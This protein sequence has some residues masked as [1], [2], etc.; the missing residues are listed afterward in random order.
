MEAC[1][2]DRHRRLGGSAVAW[3]T[4]L[5]LTC[6]LVTVIPAAAQL[7]EPLPID[8][9]PVPA[10]LPNYNGVAIGEIGSL[11]AN[12]FLVRADD[13][14]AAFYN[15]AGLTLPVQSSVSGSAGVLQ[16]TNVSPDS[17]QE[18]GGS[19]QQV[20]SLVAFVVNDLFGH[21]DWAGGFTL[22]RVNAW[23]QSSD[24]QLEL[25]GDRIMSSGVA[26]MSGWIAN[27]A[28][29]HSASERLRVGASIDAQMTSVER[30]ETLAHR[31]LS[32]T[33][34]SALLLDAH[35]SA[36]TMHL[37]GSFGTQFDITPAFRV[38]A[39]VRTP[40]VPV[41]ESG[42]FV[43]ESV[44][45]V[46]S[47]T[48]TVSLFSPDGDAEYH[49]PFEFKVG[50]A[51]IRPRARIEVDLLT[52][53]GGGTYDGFQSVEPWTVVTDSGTGG[54]PGVQTVAFTAPVIDSRAVVNVAVGGQVL[55]TSN[56]AWRL[57]G[58]YATDQSPVGDKD[59]YF[60]R[61][62]MQVVTAGVSANT[63]LFLGSVGIR[64]QRGTSDVVSI[65]SLPTRQPLTTRMKVS[66]LGVVYSISLRF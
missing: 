17:F 61:V 1:V 22:A 62:P 35:G 21:A 23:S 24:G 15:P 9:R 37:R 38:G 41:Y 2:T 45:R 66:S 42:S 34:L 48:R 5:V 49:L 6:S 65:P 52:W 54:P 55:L 14:S 25:S 27:L 36:T 3:E 40:G 44:S 16:F 46:G 10:V 50:A 26:E 31:S 57:H 60:M 51:Y 47:A 53:A 29:G 56:G 64:Y 33:G 18:R 59:T 28:V 12:A 32:G 11:E 58:G 4:A 39:L 7:A 63:K 8:V 30:D 20:P 13:S 19:F 43:Y